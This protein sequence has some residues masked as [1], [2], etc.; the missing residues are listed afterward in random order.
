MEY[1]ISLLNKGVKVSYFKSGIFATIFTAVLIGVNNL[2]DYVL[3]PVGL[4][5]L[6][7]V[8]GV[9]ILAA[10]S[11]PFNQLLIAGF[12]WIDDEVKFFTSVH[13]VVSKLQTGVR[14]TVFAFTVLTYENTRLSRLLINGLTFVGQLKDRVGMKISVRI[15]IIRKH[16]RL[17]NF[18]FIA[19][20][21]PI[22]A[23]LFAQQVYGGG[24]GR[25]GLLQYT[26]LFCTATVV[27]NAVWAFWV[28]IGIESIQALD[29]DFFT[30]ISW[31]E[32]WATWI[33]SLTGSVWQ[34]DF[35]F[36]R[37]FLGTCAI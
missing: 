24:K 14:M 6:G 11:V 22:P 23:M 13:I 28:V 25:L 35:G 30:F 33:A 17:V 34:A 31:C 29:T 5:Q 8:A 3:Y 2:F 15:A 1:V 19:A 12:N 16:S 20:Y 9:I 32:D 27:A 26:S 18:V 4:C 10:V 7:F 37:E 36:L 21:D